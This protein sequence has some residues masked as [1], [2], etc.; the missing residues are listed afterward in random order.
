MT[1]P[2]NQ[3]EAVMALARAKGILRPRDLAAE[4]IPRETLR[5]LCEAGELTRTGRGLYVVETESITENHTLA[6]VARL[7][8]RGVVCL[9]SAL[10]FHELTTQSPGEI[11]LAIPSKARRPKASATTIRSVHFSGPALTQ[12]VEEHVIEKVPVRIYSA[13]KTVADCFKARN[14]IG[15]DVALEALRDYWRKRKGTMDDLMRFAK[16]CRVARIMQPY[17]ESL[18]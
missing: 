16:I 10:R 4:G 8:P 2:V 15:L 14:K 1:K 18:A 13:A 6:E 7:V 17:L 5:R 3:A 12:G 9:L 11:W